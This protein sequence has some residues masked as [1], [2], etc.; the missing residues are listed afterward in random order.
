MKRT[1][2]IAGLLIVAAIV[3]AVLGLV[4]RALRWLL[5]VAAIVMVVGALVGAKAKGSQADR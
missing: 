4:L 2:S 5:V 1:L 3:L